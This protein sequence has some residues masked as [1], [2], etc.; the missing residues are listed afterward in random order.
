[1]C[2]DW[3]MEEM[4]GSSSGDRLWAMATGSLVEFCDQAMAGINRHTVNA[5]HAI[6]EIEARAVPNRDGASSTIAW[7]RARYR[8]NNSTARRLV[9]AATALDAAPPALLDAVN[10]G[11]VNLDQADVITATL[12]K[13]PT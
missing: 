3:E 12:G 8:V 9:N 6:R 5:L 7:V 11:D 4:R 2:D 1:M 10:S 13:L